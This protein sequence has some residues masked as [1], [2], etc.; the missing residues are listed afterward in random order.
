MVWYLVEVPIEKEITLIVTDTVKIK[1]FKM[2]SFEKKSLL[3]VGGKSKMVE[4]LCENT[5]NSSVYQDIRSAL[6]TRGYLKESES[7]ND[8]ALKAAL[9]QF[10]KDQ[11]LP[12]GNMNILTLKSLGVK[13]N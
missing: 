6:M 12:V 10:Q 8:N 4:V 7:S 1:K 5:N 2:R 9:T 3:E 13:I 11:Y